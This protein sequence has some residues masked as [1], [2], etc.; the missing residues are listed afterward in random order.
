MSHTSHDPPSP[1]ISLVLLLIAVHEPN[2]EHKLLC[3][4]IVEDAMEV[5]PECGTDLLCDLLHGQLLVCHPLPVKLQTEQPGG[6]PGGVKVGHVIV[7]VHKLLV[8][9]DD[10]VLR[11]WVIVDGCVGSNLPKSGVLD[12]TENVLKEREQLK[13][14]PCSQDNG[15][16]T[17]V[18][19]LPIYKSCI[20]QLLKQGAKTVKCYILHHITQH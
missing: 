9:G 6:D 16:P 19:E 15:A 5:L 20:Q 12:A 8:L 14:T 13:V 1:Y 11:I 3:I 18:V 10:R 2:A 17:V 4:V 7:D